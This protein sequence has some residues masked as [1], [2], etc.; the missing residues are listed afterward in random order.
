METLGGLVTAKLGNLSC[1]PQRL[2]EDTW[3]LR[4]WK[5]GFLWSLVHSKRF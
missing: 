5:L 4:W 2:P 1:G 3:P